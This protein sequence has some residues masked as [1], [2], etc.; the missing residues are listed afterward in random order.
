MVA[1][2]PRGVAAVAVLT[3]VAASVRKLGQNTGVSAADTHAG[4]NR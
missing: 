4:A 1:V 3:A 2:V